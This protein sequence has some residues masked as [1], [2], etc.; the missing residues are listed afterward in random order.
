MILVNP[1]DAPSTT[2]LCYGQQA[3]FEEMRRDLDPTRRSIYGEYFD[4]CRE[5]FTTTFPS[6]PP[7]QRIEDNQ[8]YAVMEGAIADKR[9]DTFYENCAL[10]V[11]MI[12]GLIR[13]GPGS[14]ADR[15]R[16]AIMKLP[17]YNG[18]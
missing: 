17:D 14:L 12:F 1:G 11:K 16:L 18:Q 7:L 6:P 2:R 15:L 9:P 13:L 3:N 10:S 4:L 5:K 8:F